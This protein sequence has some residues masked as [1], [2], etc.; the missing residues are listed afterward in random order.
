MDL[1]SI[2]K[3]GAVRVVGH[4]TS[5]KRL[6]QEIGDIAG[7]AYGLEAAEAVDGLQDRESLGPTGVGN[8]IALPHARLDGLDRIVGV[9]LR[10]DRPLDFGAAD[11]QPVDLVFGLFAPRDSGVDHLKALALV[12]RTMRDTAICA[13]LRAND[14]AATLYAVLT[15][16]RASQ[17][18]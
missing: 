15:E 17:A 7:Q 10:L 5:K 2:L 4:L 8:G 1:S 11:R 6:F 13:K 9:F 3:P 14:E 12:S 18:A 16:D